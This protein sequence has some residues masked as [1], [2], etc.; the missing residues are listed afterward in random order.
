MAAAGMSATPDRM[1]TTTPAGVAPSAA[2]AVLGKDVL[3]SEE[4]RC[5]EACCKQNFRKAETVGRPL[6]G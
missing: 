2:S 4:Q 5:R 3:G 1:S 6:V